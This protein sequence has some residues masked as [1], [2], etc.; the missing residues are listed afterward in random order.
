MMRVSIAPEGSVLT[1]QAE[2]VWE[3]AQEPMEPK[4]W[5]ESARAKVQ[6]AGDVAMGVTAALS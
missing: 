3:T 1:T 4:S 2:P 6:A 5:T